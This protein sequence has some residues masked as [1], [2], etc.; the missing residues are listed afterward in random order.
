MDKTVAV[1][2]RTNLALRPIE[3]ALSDQGIRYHLIGRSGFWSA[4]EVR[5]VLSYLGCV[6]YPADWLVAGAI[7]A[8]FFPSKFLPKTKL[9]AALKEQFQCETPGRQGAYF[10]Y[11]TKIPETLVDHKNV[12]ALS[13]F[14]HFLRSLIRYRDL[15]ADEALKS[16]IQALKAVEYYRDEE[17]SP[18]NDPVANLSELVK[19]A[20]RYQTIKEFMDYCRRAS[21]ASKGRKGVA[22]S[23]IH[24][25]KGLEFHTVYLIGCQEG[26]M[27]HAKATDL[28]EERAIFFVGASRA[29]RELKITYSG[30]PSPFLNQKGGII[31]SST[32]ASE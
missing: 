27:P 8:P 32:E 12:G 19:L 30:N 7:R 11:L 6:L 1:L 3:Q 29:E 22:V 9:L 2:A 21:A 10:A 31:N 25:A 18:D 23:T 4:P 20:S 14:T 24:G 15:P 16:V 13:E 5:A 28:E 17:A 26:L